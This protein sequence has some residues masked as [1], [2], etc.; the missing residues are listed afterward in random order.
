MTHY[1]YEYT[2][3]VKGTDGRT[4]TYSSFRFATLEEAQEDANA[5]ATEAWP[6][7]NLKFYRIEEISA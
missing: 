6:L 4:K 3:P 5:T 2:Q 7:D 1:A